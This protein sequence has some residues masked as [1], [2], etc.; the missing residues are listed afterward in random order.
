MKSSIVLLFLLACTEVNNWFWGTPKTNPPAQQPAQEEKEQF[1]NFSLAAKYLGKHQWGNAFAQLERLT[2]DQDKISFL[3][4]FFQINPAP[5]VLATS[6]LQQLRDMQH[7]VARYQ[8]AQNIR[9]PRQWAQHLLMHTK[10]PGSM[11][12]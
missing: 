8:E 6:Q 9:V 3:K 1:D 12:S 2:D 11:V 4:N 10:Q 7:V 5:G